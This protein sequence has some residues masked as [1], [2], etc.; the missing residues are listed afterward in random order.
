M[1]VNR[2]TALVYF[3]MSMII[4][5]VFILYWILIG[6]ASSQL[7]W[8]IKMVVSGL[9]ITLFYFIGYWGFIS[10]YLRYVF[11][12]SYLIAFAVSIQG[13]I[14]L[15]F[16]YQN[17]FKMLFKHDGVQFSISL[18]MICILL[19]F[20]IKSIRA[21]SYDGTPVSLSFPFKNGKYYV[22]EGGN[23]KKCNLINYHFKGSLHSKNNVFKS[24]QYA[25]D[26]VKLNAI[27]CFA[28]SIL[29]KQL[30]KYIIYKEDLYSPCEGTIIEVV[31]DMDNEEPFSGNH[32]Y[33]VGNHIVIQNNGINIVLGHIQRGS[34]KVNVGDYVNVGQ[35]I[36]NVG[37]SG[38]TEFPHLH[39][40]AMEA[41]EGAIWSGEGIPILFDGK[42]L[43][44]NAMLSRI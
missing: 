5:P 37:N 2:I 42:F 4:I 43:I 34:I 14:A 25:T 18:L 28:D 38:L 30:E 33:N 7:M 19:Y 44:K 23:S 17:D 3:L 16:I 21:F 12:I 32:P 22:L 9:Y 41:V 39:I 40:Q 10:Y 8:I 20:I 11:G 1:Q 27:G 6:Q 29:P 26:I 31:D 13:I 36:A 15:P 24:M 35:I